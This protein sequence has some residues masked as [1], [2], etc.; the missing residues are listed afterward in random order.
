MYKSVKKKELR[1]EG[2]GDIAHNTAKPRVTSKT[3][4]RSRKST[5]IRCKHAETHCREILRSLADS[6]M[7]KTGDESGYFR[8]NCVTQ[9]PGHFRAQYR[10]YRVLEP[11]KMTPV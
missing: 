9:V 3:Q 7:H 1:Q 11:L 5:L 10:R 8:K 4:E 6:E 2:R